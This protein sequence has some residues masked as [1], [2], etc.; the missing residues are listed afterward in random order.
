MSP[1]A[2]RFAAILFAAALVAADLSTKR[3]VFTA[4]DDMGS[5]SRDASI[6]VVP[7]FLTLRQVLNP[8]GVW[9]IGKDHGGFFKGDQL[10]KWVEYIVKTLK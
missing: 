10:G 3:A 8:G 5:G 1:I 4:I 2:L 6:V 9:G 7:G